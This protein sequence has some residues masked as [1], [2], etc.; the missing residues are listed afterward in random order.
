MNHPALL[1]TIAASISA[2]ALAQN[3]PAGKTAL[4]VQSGKKGAEAIA[5][6]GAKS[7]SKPQEP[8]VCYGGLLVDLSNGSKSAK[9]TDVRYA[10]RPKPVRDNAYTDPQTGVIKGFVIFAIRF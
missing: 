9:P 3:T 2:T 5:T 4:Q 6:P 10:P 8:R 7:Q 1:F